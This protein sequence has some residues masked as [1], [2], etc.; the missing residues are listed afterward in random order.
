MYLI[1]QS[2]IEAERSIRD[3][4]KEASDRLEEQFDKR[5]KG[6]ED[7][8]IERQKQIQSTSDGRQAQ[9]QKTFEERQTL[10]QGT[11]IRVI[12][13]LAFVAAALAIVQA[14]LQ[15][16]LTQSAQTAPRPLWQALLVLAT[17]A[18]ILFGAVM[19]TAYALRRA[20]EQRRKI[21]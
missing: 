16:G 8:F 19:L 13:A 15:S 5:L 17:L 20:D 21:E 1:E 7:T 18:A 9:L 10:L 12:E 6:L 14:T 3:S 11:Q 2:A 4:K